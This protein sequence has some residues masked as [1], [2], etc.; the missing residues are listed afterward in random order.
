VRVY[1]MLEHDSREALESRA[2]L[3]VSAVYGS[4]VARTALEALADDPWWATK[5][6]F[7]D[8]LIRPG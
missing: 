8:F 5:P 2:V 3:H 6:G 4:E 1:R 7:M